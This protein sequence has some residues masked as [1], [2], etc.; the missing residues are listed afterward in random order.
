MRGS[1]SSHVAMALL[2]VFGL[3]GVASLLLGAA[4][5]GWRWKSSRLE[6]S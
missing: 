3:A 2:G 4:V 6:L 5:L 1:I